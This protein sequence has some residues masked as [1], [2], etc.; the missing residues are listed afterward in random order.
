MLR[1]RFKVDENNDELKTS[2]FDVDKGGWIEQ[3]PETT[4]TFKRKEQVRIITY[5]LKSSK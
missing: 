5:I 2:T 3:D 1:N 4:Q